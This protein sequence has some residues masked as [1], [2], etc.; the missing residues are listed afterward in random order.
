M[1]VYQ[2]I[3]YFDT[4]AFCGQISTYGHRPHCFMLK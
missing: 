4:C 2:L 3:K 1:R